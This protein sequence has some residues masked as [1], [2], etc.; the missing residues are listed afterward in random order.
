MQNKISINKKRISAFILAGLLLSVILLS[1]AFIAIHSDHECEDEDCPI[2]D[3]I[4]QC[5]SNLRTAGSDILIQA[6]GSVFFVLFFISISLIF[7]SF[8]LKTPVTRKVR[9]ND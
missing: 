9:L 5:E 4:R 8:P 2:C 6:A 1:S 3:C 7:V